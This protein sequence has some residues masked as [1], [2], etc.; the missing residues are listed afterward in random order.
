M[1]RKMIFCTCMLTALLLG[2]CTRNTAQAKENAETAETASISEEEAKTIALNHAGLTADQVT[3]IKSGMDREDG[4]EVYDVEFYTQ[5]QKEYDYEI[6]LHT[7][8]VWN[9]DYD[10]EYYSQS[11]DVLS[12]E[13]I[14]EERAKQIALEKVSGATEQDIREFGLDYDNGKQTYEGKIYYNQKEYEIDAATG[15]I[16][17]W[18]EEPIYGGNTH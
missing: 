17:E 8:E 9:Y 18:D 16:R 3:F 12:G 1:K 15:E 4:R 2:G 13:K 5:D 7:G 6:D 10:A 14:S 11:A